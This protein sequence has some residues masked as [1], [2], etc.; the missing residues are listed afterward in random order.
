VEE[1][2]LIESNG[3]TFRDIE[4]THEGSTDRKFIQDSQ[5][6]KIFESLDVLL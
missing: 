1:H 2:P 4:Q 5:D 6:D 3:F